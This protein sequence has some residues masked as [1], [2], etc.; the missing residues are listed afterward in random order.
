[1]TSRSNRPARSLR[2]RRLVDIAA[3]D[4]RRAGLAVGKL[5]AEQKKQQT[6]L[7]ELNAYRL[8]YADKSRGI[9]DS[10]SAHWKDYQ[11]FLG[12][13]DTAVHAQQQIVRDAEQGIAAARQR[14]IAKRQRLD[15]LNKVYERA[16]L[17]EDRKRDRSEQKRLDDLVRPGTPFDS[18]RE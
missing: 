9:S 16:R 10:Q 2:L 8:A 14:W 5:I 17:D 13:L 7:G 18:D 11:D 4:E 12:R 6:Q 15:S 3:A 1:M